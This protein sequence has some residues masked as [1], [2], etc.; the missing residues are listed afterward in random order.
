[1]VDDDKKDI[2]SKMRERDL[3]DKGVQDANENERDARNELRRLDQE[4]R[5][6]KNKLTGYNSE[7]SKLKDQILALEKEKDTYA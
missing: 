5:K 4:H 2:D 1:M 3:L 7:A 6:L